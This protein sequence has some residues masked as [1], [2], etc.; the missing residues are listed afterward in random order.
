MVIDTLFLVTLR[1]RF[2]DEGVDTLLFLLWWMTYQT[3]LR[4]SISAVHES[5][6]G[7][8][9]MDESFAITNNNAC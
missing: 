1:E 7:P 8:C 3:L 2:E 6:H 9:I 4:Y 5:Y